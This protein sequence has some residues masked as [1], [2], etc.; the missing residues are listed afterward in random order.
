VTP[1][2]T[3]SGRELQRAVRNKG[4]EEFSSLALPVARELA[5]PH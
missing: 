5:S 2:A 3:R 1:S 4:K